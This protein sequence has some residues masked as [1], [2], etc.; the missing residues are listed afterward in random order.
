MLSRRS[1]IAGAEAHTAKK[2]VYSLILHTGRPLSVFSSPFAAVVVFFSFAQ[3][4][5]RLASPPCRPSRSLRDLL[6]SRSPIFRFCCFSTQFACQNEVT[7]M[8]VM[9][10]IIEL[11]GI[12]CSKLTCSVRLHTSTNG[13][14]LV[15]I[16]LSST[17]L[18]AVAIFFS[19]RIP[20]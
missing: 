18:P 4:C 8:H 15:I 19:V 11:A 3:N 12:H 17:A 20:A 16:Q 6:Y 14:Q 10:T 7:A 13:H 9:C 1:K 2:S 5:I